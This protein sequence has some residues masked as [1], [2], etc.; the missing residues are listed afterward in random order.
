[1]LANTWFLH[2]LCPQR[3]CP[4]LSSYEHIHVNDPTLESSYSANAVKELH[5]TYLIMQAAY[6]SAY[7]VTIFELFK[8]KYNASSTTNITI[9]VVFFSLMDNNNINNN[10]N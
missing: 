6:A 9:M 5:G 10:N 3:N 7:A 2:G 8:N 4:F 1:M